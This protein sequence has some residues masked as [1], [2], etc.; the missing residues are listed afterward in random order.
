MGAAS[1]E[2]DDSFRGQLH[3]FLK[4]RTVHQVLFALL[5]LDLIAVIVG[6]FLELAYTDSKFEHSERIIIACID[7]SNAR[8]LGSSA[9]S[10]AVPDHYGN[11][12]LHHAEV[13]LVKVSLA[14]LSVFLIEHVLHE[15]ASPP[16]H[17]LDW[18]N[19]LDM[20]VVVVS[21]CL[22]IG[23]LSNGKIIP[24]SGGVIVAARLWRFARIVHTVEEIA[25]D[26][27]E[28]GKHENTLRAGEQHERTTTSDVRTV[29]R[30]DRAY[31]E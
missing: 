28:E 14:I 31:T 4:H 12:A 3:R 11:E 30:I 9:V 19:I 29:G 15:C 23:V 17:R 22:E 27:S 24:F 25:E 8:R 10:C 5:I 18:G 1:A 16:E 20:S 7:A 13:A 2:S 26:A 6:G 21:M